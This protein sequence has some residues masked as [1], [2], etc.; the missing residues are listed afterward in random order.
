[1]LFCSYTL[2]ILTFSNPLAQNKVFTVLPIF[3][4]RHQDTFE[5]SRH[6]EKGND[7]GN[8]NKYLIK[9]VTTSRTSL[10]WKFGKG[11]IG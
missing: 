5:D 2:A 7:L 4:Q 11:L 6:P 10:C 9:S 1:M 8:E 3:N